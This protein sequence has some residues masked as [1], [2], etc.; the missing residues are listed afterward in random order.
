VPALENEHANVGV[1]GES[2]GKREACCA[3]ADED[4]VE[5]RAD[6]DGGFGVGVGGRGGHLGG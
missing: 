6:D 4:V 2:T 1:L 3:A 5:G